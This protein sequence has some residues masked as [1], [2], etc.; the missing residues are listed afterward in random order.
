MADRN[1]AAGSLSEEA[2]DRRWLSI[3]KRVITGSKAFL[4]MW[5]LRWKV[6]GGKMAL[7]GSTMP[8][9][10]DNIELGSQQ[11]LVKISFDFVYDRQIEV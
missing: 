8:V 5:F 6:S 9:T 2:E 4:I 11:A 3:S 1:S 7:S 10:Y